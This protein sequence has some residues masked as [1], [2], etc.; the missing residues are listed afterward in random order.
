ML[1][2]LPDDISCI[3]I[4]SARIPSSARKATR[5]L[6][7]SG[8][9]DDAGSSF[10][11]LRHSPLAPARAFAALIAASSP[12]IGIASVC[13]RT[14]S[15]DKKSISGRVHPSCGMSSSNSHG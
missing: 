14:E 10:V 13:L 9:T 7:G 2:R 3:A 12:G 1:E 15:S 11:L 8:S 4:A 6:G 5:R